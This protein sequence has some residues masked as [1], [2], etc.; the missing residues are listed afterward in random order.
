MRGAALLLILAT[1]CGSQSDPAPE[2]ELPPRPEVPHLWRTI[3]S[4]EGEVRLVV[5]TDLTVIHTSGSVHGFRDADAAAV[6]TVAAIPPSHLIQ[7]RGGESG[8]EWA[9]AG[10]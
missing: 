7:P 1:A 4:D 10:G 2:P 9:D 8:V 3:E 5:P 6:L